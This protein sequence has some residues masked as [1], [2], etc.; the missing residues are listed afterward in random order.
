MH[1]ACAAPRD[2]VARMRYAEVR[3][4]RHPQR[5]SRAALRSA[6]AAASSQKE[7]HEH[8]IRRRGRPRQI[9]LPAH[10][11]APR[12]P[13]LGRARTDGGVLVVIDGSAVE[14]QVCIRSQLRRGGVRRRRRR[15]QRV[16]REAAQ[17]AQ[18]Q[19]PCGCQR[20]SEAASG[21]DVEPGRGC[22]YGGKGR[23]QAQVSS[24]GALEL[25]AARDKCLRTFGSGCVGAAEQSARHWARGPER[26][27]AAGV[28]LT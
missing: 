18:K 27:A 8:W 25:K 11:P 22:L 12:R 4:R 13:C 2:H 26:A 20:L 1:R 10:C 16:A 9:G 6:A 7:A 17:H 19:R 3:G 14:F 15:R 5:R 28:R 21:A 24:I 23:A